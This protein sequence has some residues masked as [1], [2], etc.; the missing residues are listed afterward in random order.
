MRSEHTS[1]QKIQIVTCQDADEASEHVAREVIRLIR[2]RN[3][4]SRPTVLGLAT[5]STPIPLY[6]KLIRAHREEGLSFKHV[7]TFNLDEYHGLDKSHPESYWHFMHTQLFDHIDIDPK[8]I[9]IPDGKVTED[10]ILE[11]CHDYESRIESAGGLDI[12]ILGIG[13][14]G[15]IG[16]NEPGSTVDSMTRMVTL[17]P[18]TR[19]DAAHSFGGEAAVPTHAITMGVSTILKSRRIYLIAWGAA[20]AGIVAKTLEVEPTET[21]PASFLQK[22]EATTFYIDHAAASELN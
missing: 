7:I 6:E 21:L 12:Q 1:S 19:K 11:Y 3:E 9:H 10:A 15:H 18:L 5:G 4:A 17:D 13:R 2:E 22:H 16:F 8:N 14:T 20:K